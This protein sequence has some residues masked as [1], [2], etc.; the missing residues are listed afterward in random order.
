MYLAA[1][2][3][4]AMGRLGYRLGHVILYILYHL[5]CVVVL[6]CSVFFSF[7]KTGLSGH[8]RG[9]RSLYTIH[10]FND[11]C[12]KLVTD[13]IKTAVK[14]KHMRIPSNPEILHLY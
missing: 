5:L 7:C 2:C 1:G 4:Y 6:S 11:F 8:G 3:M 9:L 12:V 14:I 13:L 10:D